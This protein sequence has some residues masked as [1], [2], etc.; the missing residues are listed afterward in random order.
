MLRVRSQSGKT[1]IV[2][3]PLKFIEILD[4]DGNVAMVFYKE[5]IMDSEAVTCI[6]PEDDEATSY[7]K[8]Y[9]VKWSK[10]IHGTWPKSEPMELNIH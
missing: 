1:I 5:D 8:M 2:E 6:A 3:E 10:K 4:G 9:G 7:S